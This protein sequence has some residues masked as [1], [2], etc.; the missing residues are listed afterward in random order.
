MCCG[1]T[2]RPGIVLCALLAGCASRYEYV[3]TTNATADMQGRVAAEYPLPPNAPH[4]NLWICSYG[5]TDVTP[6]GAPTSQNLRALHLRVV[7]ANNGTVP[8]TF[9]T[10]EQRVDLRGRGPVAP[11]FAS[12]SPGAS[13]PLV[14]VEPNSER[15]IDLFFLVPPDLQHAE[16]V[17]QFDALW[18]VSTDSGVIAER[19]PF[20]RLTVEPDEGYYDRWDYGPDYYWGGPYW[21]DPYL[22]YDYYGLPPTYFGGGVIIH[23][24]P[25]FGGGFH[26]GGGFRGGGFHGG[27]FRGGG[28]HGGAT[29]GGGGHR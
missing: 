29:H 2:L 27:G 15:V 28:F 5:F 3:P 16:Q 19:T 9:D 13:P 21:T 20:E 8:W 25:H 1:M 18:R 12:T 11:A 6:Q 10:R 14:T 24:G 4:G 17:P 22:P 26:H 7:V 23:R